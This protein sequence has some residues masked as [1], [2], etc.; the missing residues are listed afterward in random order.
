[1]AANVAELVYQRAACQ[2][3]GVALLT[4]ERAISYAELRRLVGIAAHFLRTQGI[5]AGEVVGM[6]MAQIP[7]HLVVLLALAQIGAVSLPLHP[8]VPRERRQLAARRFGARWVVSGRSELALEGVGFADLKGLSFETGAPQDYRIAPVADGDPMRI[9]ISSGTSGDPK[10]MA[11]THAMIGTREAT[12]GT[13]A[14]AASRVLTMDLNFIAGFRPAIGALARGSSVVFAASLAEPH[15]IA[16]LR[17]HRVTHAS[18][19]PLQAKALA[20]LAAAAGAACPDLACLRILGG[21]VSTETLRAIT[22]HL[23]QNVHVIYGS[24]ESG[25]VT[26]ATPQILAGH[27]DSV[28]R[29]CEWARVEVV[30]DAGAP[31]P[32]GRTGALRIRSAHQVEGY[33]RDEA[34]T[35]QHFREG[36]F[37]P[38]DLGHFD[39]DGLLYIEGRSDDQLNIGGLK[40]DPV[41]IEQTLERH[42]GVLEAG[43]FSFQAEE[44]G[45]A[46]AVGLVLADGTLL[47]AVRQHAIK[48]LGPLAPRHYLRC[49]ALPR[50]PTG[51]LKRLEL[52]SACAEGSATN[53]A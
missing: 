48:Q 24:T 45:E 46:L 41:D 15:L 37:Y 47:E 23:T 7:L 20:G 16:A 30:D 28:G 35:R 26:H 9:A 32:A 13:A 36:W 49:A 29:V 53:P 52:A 5:G 21:A 1:M 38:G 18:V 4:D 2:P 40:V 10:G 11:L 51:K 8:A 25:A 42:P 14:D 31:Q 44:G 6:S 12:P 19:S 39:E 17:R 3:D 34:R 33:Y 50:T 22:A 43:A 27:P